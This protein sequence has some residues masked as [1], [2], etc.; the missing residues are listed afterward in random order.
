MADITYRLDR[1][2]IIV[3]VTICG[4]THFFKVRFVLDTGASHTIIDYRIAE[5]LGYSK[6]N[7]VAPSRVSSAAGKE[8]GYRLRIESIETLGKKISPFE[9]ACH[10][11]YEQRPSNSCATEGLR[12]RW[13]Q[14]WLMRA[15]FS[16]ASLI[17]NN[18]PNLVTTRG[19]FL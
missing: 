14:K 9:V 12:D 2:L 6:Q 3:P 18:L 10:Q 8:E 5:S 19:R 13:F 11:L 15:L 7:V 17:K 4:P 16:K 1:E